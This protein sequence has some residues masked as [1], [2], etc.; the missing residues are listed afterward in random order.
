VPLAAIDGYLVASGSQAS[1]KLF[2]EGFEA[3]VM[4]RNPP[5]A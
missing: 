3:A 5:R 1:G 2:G 4:R